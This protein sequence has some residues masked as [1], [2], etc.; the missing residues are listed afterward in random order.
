[1]TKLS[2]AFLYERDQQIFDARATGMSST[3]IAKRFD[4]T[5]ATVDTAIRRHINQLNRTAV[6]AY[7]E[8]LAMELGRLDKLQRAIWPHTQPRRQTLD[9]GTQITLEPDLKAVETVL[10]IMQQRSKLMG[11]D[12]TQIMD[13]TPEPAPI[14]STLSGAKKL[15]TGEEKTDEDEARALIELSIKAGILDETVGRAI[16]ESGEIIEAEVI[17]DETGATE[18][19]E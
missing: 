9:D 7:P 2:K 12:V 15:E 4:V 13:I 19:D 16:L 5:P 6:L 1:M 11:M 14:K 10:R 18:E 17:E 3:E 8:V